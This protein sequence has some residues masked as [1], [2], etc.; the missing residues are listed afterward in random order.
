MTG[1]R[2][3][4]ISGYRTAGGMLEAVYVAEL[5]ESR[6]MV[7]SF[8]VRTKSWG[9]PRWIAAD[10]LFELPIGNPLLFAALAHKPRANQ[11][12]EAAA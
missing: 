6:A 3:N 2:R 1:P 5:R 12:Q 7:R 8:L 4:G 9:A 11:P 10:R